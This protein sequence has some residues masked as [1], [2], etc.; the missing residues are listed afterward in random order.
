MLPRSSFREVDH[1]QTREKVTLIAAIA[2][3]SLLELPNVVAA[4]SGVA[5]VNV[6]IISIDGMRVDYL[7]EAAE[8][9]IR[10]PTL[11]NL[12]KQGT[13][14]EAAISVTPAMTFPAHTSMVTGV[15]PNKHGILI[16]CEDSWRRLRSHGQLGIP[17][18]ST[19]DHHY[20]YNEINATSLFTFLPENNITKVVGVDW[21]VTVGLEALALYPGNDDNPSNFDE[22]EFLYST[23]KGDIT[24]EFF[25]EIQ[26]FWTLNDSQRCEL[27][28]QMIE[29]Y[30]PQMM[31]FHMND[32]DYVE[33]HS[34]YM[35]P[36]AIETLEY[37][38]V[39]IGKILATLEKV[40]MLNSTVVIITSD[41]GFTNISQTV[42][43]QVVFN[44]FGLFDDGTL[45][46]YDGSGG[47]LFPIYTTPNMTAFGE[48]QLKYAVGTIMND[49][50]NGVSR[51]YSQQEL[52]QMGAFGPDVY[53]ALEGNM[54]VDFGN[55]MTG[56][57]I[58]PP[59]DLGE[60]GYT[61]NHTEMYASFI[62][63]GPGICVNKTIS[64]IHLYDIAPTIAQIFGLQYP[65]D[66]DGRVLKEVFA[67]ST[68]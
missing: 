50:A 5:S 32:L 19:C 20:F 42:N 27:A 43:P 53:M 56:S 55:A 11:Q 22:A 17:K 24:K 59:H 15:V 68:C 33:H 3:L 63:A 21:P 62:I 18:Q 23:L 31:Y 37:I 28:S 57:L 16:N 29:E 6:A 47:G 64:P 46:P 66:I 45:Y 9:G 52:M 35:S 13:T 51:A 39:G 14:A 58:T 4:S 44:T 34:G 10:I 41:H 8:K 7:F 12:M 38:D 54:S 65:T 60:H 2:L 36:K 61:S 26:L 30:K 25:K 1:A 48:A 67:S 49:S 40:G